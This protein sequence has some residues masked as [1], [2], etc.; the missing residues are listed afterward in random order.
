MR[1]RWN[2][3][4]GDIAAGASVVVAAAMAM[5]L[6]RAV[7]ESRGGKDVWNRQQTTQRQHE[8]RRDEQRGGLVLRSQRSRRHVLRGD[9]RRQLRSAQHIG[10]FSDQHRRGQQFKLASDTKLHQAVRIAAP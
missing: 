3:L 8:E 6:V 5:R 7:L 1:Q 2:S 4:V 9:A 10:Q